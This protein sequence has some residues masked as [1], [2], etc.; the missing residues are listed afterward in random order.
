MSGRQ[1]NYFDEPLKF[2]PERFNR[3]L[4]TIKNYTYFPFSLGARNCIGQNFAQMV[5]KVFIAKIIKNFDIILDKNQDFGIV[6]E[7][8]LRPIDGTRCFLLPRSF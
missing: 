6:Q 1:E 8:T 7:A 5:G 4:N 3:D 2:N